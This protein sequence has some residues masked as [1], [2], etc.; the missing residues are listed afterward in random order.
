MLNALNLFD[1]VRAHRERESLP[2]A[3]RAPHIYKTVHVMRVEMRTL[4]GPS[5]ILLPV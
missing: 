2:Y 4:R 1:Y 3:T 5:I